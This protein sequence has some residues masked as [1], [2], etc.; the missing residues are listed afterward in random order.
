MADLG[1]QAVFTD[2]TGAGAGA[3]QP[4]TFPGFLVL[5]EPGAPSWFEL[6]TPQFAKALDFYETV[7][8]WTTTMVGDSDEFRY[9]VMR[10]PEGDGDFAGIMDSSAFPGSPPSAW[11][12]YWHVDDVAGALKSVTSLGGSVVDEATETPYGTLGTAKDPAG[13]RFKLRSA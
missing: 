8:Q 4:G 2:P 10:N 7:F 12:V 6:H 3:W 1:V 5:E 13:A 9:A 11:S